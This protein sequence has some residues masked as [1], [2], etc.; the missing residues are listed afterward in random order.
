MSIFSRVFTDVDRTTRIA[1]FAIGGLVLARIVALMLTPLQLGPDEAQYWRWAQTLDW[2]YY[3]KP[4]LIAWMIAATTS[5]FGDAEWAVRLGAPLGHG[6]AAFCLF[7]LGKRMHGPQAGGW[8]AAVYI[9]MPGVWLSSGIVSTDAALLPCWS[10]ALLALWRLRD[11]ASGVPTG[12]ALGAAIGL[13]FLAK[14][15]ALYILL[16]MALTVLIDTPTRRALA[17]R[18][19]LAALVAAAAIATPN[20]LWNAA[21]DFATVGHTADNTNWQAAGLHFEHLWKY[22]TDQMGVFGPFSFLVLI[23]GLVFIAP[24][25]DHDSARADRWLL[26]FILP[27]LLVIAMQAVISRAHANWAATAYPAA[28]VLV[29]AWALRANW[30]RWLK[31]GVGV[32]VIAG[33][34]FVTLSIGQPLADRVGFENAFKRARGWDDTA[35]ELARIA[36]ETGARAIVFDERENWHGVDYYSRDMQMAPI[37]A[38]RLAASGAASF[39]EMAAPLEVGAPEPMLIASYRKKFRPRIRADFDMIQEAGYLEIPLGPTKIRRF[40]LY[41]ARGYDP[42]ERTAEYYDRF[43]DL[44]ED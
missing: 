28:S 29:A 17:S 39:P 7:L 43:Q 27:A 30:M 33:L 42:L 35:A 24:K 8:A 6:I 3:S 38:W 31:L 32:N 4:P 11:G 20:I 26:C 19:G 1:A 34:T 44:A 16:G 41:I 14:Y 12:L 15:A 22:V 13:G 2:G 21:N 23:G 10:A 5:V 18:A 25:T 40:K 37:L 36:E 9:L